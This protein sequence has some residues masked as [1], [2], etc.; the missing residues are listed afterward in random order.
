M[1]TDGLGLMSQLRFGCGLAANDPKLVQNL[2]E[3][4]FLSVSLHKRGMRGGKGS[5]PSSEAVE[6]AHLPSNEWVGLQF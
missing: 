4:G 2:A 5:K 1:S 3:V 6:H